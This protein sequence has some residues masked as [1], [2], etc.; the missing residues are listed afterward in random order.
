METH[1]GNQDKS[2]V[3]VL[4]HV[5]LGLYQDMHKPVVWRGFLVP[6]VIMHSAFTRPDDRK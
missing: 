5:L 6:Q 1:E 4:N 3:I 2:K